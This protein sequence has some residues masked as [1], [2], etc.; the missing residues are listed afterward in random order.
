MSKYN[1]FE[2][3]MQSVINEADTKCRKQKGIS[4]ADAYEAP[5]TIQEMIRI[6]IGK[7]W[8]VFVAL[9][10]LLALGPFA[11]GA[12]LLG[13]GATGAGTVVLLALASFGGVAAIRL[14]YKNRILP[15]AVN[16]TGEKY[17]SDFN[18]HIG[19]VVYIDSLTNSASDYLLMRATR[20]FH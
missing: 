10:A 9:V 3:F 19:D 7:G 20:F 14:L 17:K 15:I 18:S 2:D 6:V 12:A 5:S 4:L 1:N 16:E 13:F 11:F 8:W